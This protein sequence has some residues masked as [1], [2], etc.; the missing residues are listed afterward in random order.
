M[1]LTTLLDQID[2]VSCKDYFLALSFHGE[3]K[4]PTAEQAMATTDPAIREFARLRQRRGGRSQFA[5][6]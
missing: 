5:I 2:K 6:S 3:P 1:R 4:D